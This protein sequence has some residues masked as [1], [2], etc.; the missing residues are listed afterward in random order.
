MELRT[1]AIASVAG[2]RGTGK[3][4]LAKRILSRV[5]GD[6]IVYD[7]MWEYPRAI[8][9]H[10]HSDSREDFDRFMATCWDKGNIYIAVDEAERYF[11]GKKALTPYSAKIVNTG[12]HRNI[13]LLL[14][15]RRIAELN[16][17]AFGLSDT[18]IMF[19]MF[20]PNDIRYI[21]EFFGDRAEELKDLPRFRYKVFSMR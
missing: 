4:S 7:P 2:M 19:Q 11:K 14:I 15:T 20:L 17:T 8:S 1:D 21:K 13:G 9:F 3:T 10:P 6:V 18:V 16:K 12:R 5:K